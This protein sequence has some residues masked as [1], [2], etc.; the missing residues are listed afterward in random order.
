MNLIKQAEQ[1]VINIAKSFQD[2]YQIIE[3]M[4]F[5]GIQFCKEWIGKENFFKGISLIRKAINAEQNNAIAN[6]FVLS[7]VGGEA[8]KQYSKEMFEKYFDSKSQY[9]VTH[10]LDKYG[11]LPGWK[12][13][14]EKGLRK[15]AQELITTH[16]E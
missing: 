13:D 1:N 3:A 15:E 11:Q 16:K 9:N 8:A 14:D 12:L 2:F 5:F 6:C 7:G 10:F 4:E